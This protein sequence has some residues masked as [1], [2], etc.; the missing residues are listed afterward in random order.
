MYSP[1]TYSVLGSVL[2]AYMLE[3]DTQTYTSQYNMHLN[4]LTHK[5]GE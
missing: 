1:A 5:E 3:T 2:E 4:G